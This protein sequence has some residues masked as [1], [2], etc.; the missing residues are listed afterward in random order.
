MESFFPKLIDEGYQVTSSST[1]KYNC[2]AWAAMDDNRWWWPDTQNQYF[3]PNEISRSET[4]ESFIEAF[5]MLGY[6]VCEDARF[7]EGHEKVAIFTDQYDKPT[8]AARQLPSG[9]WTSK[10]GKMVDIEHG[11]KGVEG[12]HYGEVRV[13]LRRRI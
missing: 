4:I 13:I 5:Q 11:L 12:V 6:T 7:E 9:K 1:P 3:W 8:H 2:I 10:L